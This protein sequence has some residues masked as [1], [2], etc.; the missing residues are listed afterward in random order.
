MS[1][2]AAPSYMARHTQ[3]RPS[4]PI[5]IPS[6]RRKISRRPPIARTPSTSIL[7]TTSPEQLMFHMSPD[8]SFRYSPQLSRERERFMYPYPTINKVT[9]DAQSELKPCP[10]TSPE[11]VETLHTPPS[12]RTRFAQTPPQFGPP[13]LRKITGFKP[14]VPSQLS[15][16]AS[17]AP[18]T[19][20]AQERSGPFSPPPRRASFAPSPWVL[21]AKPEAN[22]EVGS[23]EAPALDFEKYLF[24]RLDSLM[25]P[26][27]SGLQHGAL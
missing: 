5:E 27:F 7:S 14:V 13:P 8:Y 6:V 12:Y 18:V 9:Q 3:H 23:P 11:E 17:Q 4:T 25:L 10:S 22:V 2:A 24:K 1:L 16:P 21:T 26:S 20:L 19:P 15:T